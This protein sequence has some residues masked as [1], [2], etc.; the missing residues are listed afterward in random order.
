MNSFYFKTI[1]V[2]QYNKY[3]HNHP[4]GQCKIHGSDHIQIVFSAVNKT[5]T[6][7][8]LWLYLISYYVT[9]LIIANMY[10]F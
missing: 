10:I 8:Y 1:F 9:K 3:L 2:I 7:K 6:I 5:N 4:L